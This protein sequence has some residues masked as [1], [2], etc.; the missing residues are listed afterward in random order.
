MAGKPESDPGAYSMPDK[1][2]EAMVATAAGYFLIRDLPGDAA[3]SPQNFRRTMLGVYRL[4]GHADGRAVLAAGLMAAGFTIELEPLQI[5]TPDVDP[6]TSLTD[7]VY[8]MNYYLIAPTIIDMGMEAV[9]S[10]SPNYDHEIKNRA[11]DIFDLSD[12]AVALS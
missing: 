6:E 8:M 4:R 9:V 12:E 1:L 3:E 2:S 5:T 7:R 11:M 10:G